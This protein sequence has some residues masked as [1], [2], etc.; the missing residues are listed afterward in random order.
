M[1]FILYVAGE[2]PCCCY[3]NKA[4]LL[5]SCDAEELC[6]YQEALVCAAAG[7][8]SMV[9]VEYRARSASSTSERYTALLGRCKPLSYMRCALSTI[10]DDSPSVEGCGR[11]RAVNLKRPF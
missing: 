8:R 2:A 4:L 9:V 6:I 5:L 11:E 3:R 7:R 1:C 10:P